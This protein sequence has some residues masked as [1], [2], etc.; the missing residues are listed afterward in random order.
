VAWFLTLQDFAHDVLVFHG[1][2]NDLHPRF[3]T[4]FRPDYSH[5]R[6]PL[7]VEQARGIERWIVRA[8]DLYLHLR[9]RKTGEIDI[10]H[11]TTTTPEEYEPLMKEDRLPPETARPFRRNVAS[12]AA[13]A[14]GLGARVV[15]LTVP[16]QPGF[17][18]P[19]VW[20]YG[21][22]EHNRIVADLAREQG[23]LLVD[24]ARAFDERKDELGAEFK[25]IVH[26]RPAG[27]RVKAEL[28]AR[29]LLEHWVPTLPAEGLR[30][31]Q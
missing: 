7:H 18:G 26:L 16:V 24:A 15:F 30:P 13:S 4:G 2:V 27:N 28:V 1:G 22:D 12:I 20:L 8:S 29:A 6:I 3:R 21:I 14:R 10:G 17:A 31:P 23:Y 9:L 19:G 5:W 25:D 11:L